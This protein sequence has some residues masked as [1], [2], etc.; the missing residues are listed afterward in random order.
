MERL[1]RFCDLRSEIL[2][3]RTRATSISRQLHGW[4]NSLQNT[5]IKGQRYLTDKS[6]RMEKA[7]REREEFLK[8][9]E[10]LR[11]QI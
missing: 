9:L 3:L 7:K 8:E 6:G 2:D 1:P 5:D 10:A 11:S 4:C